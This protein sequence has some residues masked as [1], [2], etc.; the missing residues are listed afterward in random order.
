MEYRIEVSPYSKNHGIKLLWEDDACIGCRIENGAAVICANQDGLI[1]LARHLLTIAQDTAPE[2]SHIHLD[3]YNGL[4]DGSCEL[5]IT[6]K[7]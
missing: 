3:E 1:S 5:I 6:K 2:Y 7:I 4:E